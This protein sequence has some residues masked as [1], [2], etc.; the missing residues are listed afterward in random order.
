MS[1]L[2][3]MPRNRRGRLYERTGLRIRGFAGVALNEAL[4][5]FSLAD[6]AKLTVVRP[7]DLEGLPNDVH[8]RL[9]G[10]CSSNWS[11]VT[12]GLPDGNQICIVNPTHSLERTRATLMEEIAHVVLGH[13]PTRIHTGAGGLPCREYNA[14]N[15]QAAYGVGAAALVPYTALF[16]GLM[17]GETPESIALRYG[18]TRELVGYRIKITMLWPLYKSKAAASGSA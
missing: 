17:D 9:V 11:A 12:F 1:K 6:Y 10:R 4:D 16:V 13:E 15:E 3:L 8:Q 7:A 2:L 18:V 14:A 5:P